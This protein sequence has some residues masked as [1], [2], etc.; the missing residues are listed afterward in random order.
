MQEQI[1]YS[2]IIALGFNEEYESDA[3]YFN[4]YGYDY[5]IITLKLSKWIYLDWAK[6]TRLCEMIRTNKEQDVIKRKPIK[7]LS[8]LKEIVD[9]FLGKKE[10]DV[11]YSAYAKAA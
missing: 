7:N 11:D 2:D 8:E 9:F 3:V 1:N 4:Q 5:T 10:S 6:E